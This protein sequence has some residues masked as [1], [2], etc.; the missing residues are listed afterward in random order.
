MCTRECVY[1]PVRVCLGH[2]HLHTHSLVQLPP[3]ALYE[4]IQHLM[5]ICKHA[6]GEEDG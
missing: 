6:I 1:V 5:G 2:T 3:M 4:D